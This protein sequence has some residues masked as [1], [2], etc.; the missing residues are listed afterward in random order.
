MGTA[1]PPVLFLPS[2]VSPPCCPGVPPLYSVCAQCSLSPLYINYTPVME[3]ISRSTRGP[4][5]AHKLGTSTATLLFS[6]GTLHTCLQSR[7]AQQGQRRWHYQ[8]PQTSQTQSVLDTSRNAP[9]C[10]ELLP[11]PELYSLTTHTLNHPEQGH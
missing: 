1:A 2:P 3:P 7:S 4:C 8:V 6:A 11:G 9:G 5:C 10:T